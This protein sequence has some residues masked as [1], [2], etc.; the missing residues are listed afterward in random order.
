MEVQTLILGAGA[1]GMMCAAHAGPARCSST[2]PAAPGEKI[3]ISGGGRCNFT[4]IGTSAGTVHL[5]ATRISPNRRSSRYTPWDFMALVEARGIA[6][7]EK[8]LGQLFCDRSAKDIIAML[9]AD[10]RRPPAPICGS[11]TETGD[12]G[13]DG[14]RFRVALRRQ[15]QS[16]IVSARH[17][18]VATGGK[19]I[20]K[21]GATGLAYQHRPP[22]RPRGHRR[23]ARAGAA[24]LPRRQP[25][26]RACRA[27]PCRCARAPNGVQLRRGDAV[28]PS[29]PFRP[30]DP[31]G[32]V[33]LARGRGDRASTCC[34]GRDL[35]ARLRAAPQGIGQ[36]AALTTV[37]GE[38]LPAR[39]A[40]HLAGALGLTGNLADQT[41][42]AI[43]AI[44]AALSA[45]RL[46]PA[47]PKATAPPK[48]RWAGSTPMALSSTTMDVKDR[49]RASI[50]SANASMSPAGSAATTSS[51]P[52][53]RPMRRAGRSRRA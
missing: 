13:H 35:G 22:V 10:G 9:L 15:G 16:T 49:G 30:G 50:S 7:H 28:H 34:P 26:Q 42:A 47:A 19:S 17:L 32:L 2:M 43:D 53:P 3:R 46:R 44:A 24:H 5:G 21:M 4:N 52:G 18:V 29:R 31:A 33:L 12:I 1:A 41:D 37:L 39:L 8:T 27:W 40:E 23:R 11:R 36:A 38:H 51:G 14:E 25:S 48:S 45:W 6:W 20:P